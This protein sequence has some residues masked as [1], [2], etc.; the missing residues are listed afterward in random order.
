MVNLYPNATKEGEIIQ[1]ETFSPKHGKD[2]AYLWVKAGPLYDAQ[3]NRI[4][5]T[6]SFRD[7]TENKRLEAEIKDSEKKFREIFDSSPI[8]ISLL[9]SSG[10]IVNVN[11][12]FLYL[13]GVTDT[14]SLKKYNIFKDADL[15]SSAIEKLLAGTSFRLRRTYDPASG[16]AK[17]L[18]RSYKTEPLELES[19]FTPL[20][21]AGHKSI[22]GW[23]VQNIDVTEITRLA[24]DLRALSQKLITMQET[25]R[26]RLAH[27]LHDG[28]GMML[29][30]LRMDIGWMKKKTRNPELKAKLD[31][32]SSNALEAA[33]ELSRMCKGLRPLVLDS[34]GLSHAVL[35]LVK[36]FET[37]AQG[38][39][40]F[41]MDVE[42]IS[43]DLIPKETAVSLFRIL[44]EGLTNIVKH[45]GADKVI[46]KLFTYGS[47]IVLHIRDNG[48]GISEYESNRLGLGILGIKERAAYCGGTAAVSSTSEGGV[49]IEIVA[50]LNPAQEG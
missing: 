48:K 6:E 40:S 19:I 34:F 36:D 37:R 13:F 42:Q 28:L 38:N 4:G 35:E 23:L 30:A 44:Q 43:R 25:E 46:I 18:L 16:A 50:P 45:S 9:D 1:S 22:R 31:E 5:A 7:I 29:A 3:N 33:G 41:E 20:M 39:I 47:D 8:A 2:G 24:D 26:S 12:A 27:E 32:L 15:P 21:T 10:N 11:R 17:T 14:S 49:V